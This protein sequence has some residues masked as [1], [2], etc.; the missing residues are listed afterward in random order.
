VKPEVNNR[1]TNNLTLI[2]HQNLDLAV[3]HDT[4]AAVCSSQVLRTG[5][6]LLLGVPTSLP[7]AYRAESTYNTDDSAILGNIVRCVHTLDECWG[8]KG[9]K[10][11]KQTKAQG[12]VASRSASHC[13]REFR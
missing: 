12:H 5:L 8:E 2:V 4:H 13:E 3:L 10:E 11:R 6:A 7:L 1:D 9:A